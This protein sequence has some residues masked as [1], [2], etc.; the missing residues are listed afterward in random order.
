MAP[1]QPLMSADLRAFEWEE[2]QRLR[3]EELMAICD[4]I[5]LLNED[6]EYNTNEMFEKSPDY[7]GWS[8]ANGSKQ[9]QP[10]GAR[11]AAQKRES[12]VREREEVERQ[13]KEKGRVE[14][15]EERRQETGMKKEGREMRKG[16]VEMVPGRESEQIDED[17]TGW[18]EVRRRTR[19][20]TTEAE[21]KD[22][23]GKSKTAQIFVKMD[24]SRT[25]AM[26]VG[27][28][29]KVSDMMKRI[30]SSKDVYVTSEGGDC[31]VVESTRTR[32]SRW[33]RTKPQS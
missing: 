4:M 15:D 8:S 1:A 23:R 27:Q 26:D 7:V 24:G 3:V 30:P 33:R 19:R 5:K 21:H 18:V 20:R 2:C 12:V 9:Q 11:Q 32:K 13:K 10:Q 29:D 14:G 17:A 28:N 25:I 31:E 16:E 6:L 22:E